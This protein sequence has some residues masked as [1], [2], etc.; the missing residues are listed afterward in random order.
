MFSL[1]PFV[2]LFTFLSL[3]LFSLGQDRYKIKTGDPNGI[4]KWYMGRQIA[5]VM[6]HYG[7][8][9]LE[10]EEREME[11]NTSLLLKNLSVK[12]GMLIADIGAGSGYHSALLSKMV[13]TGKVFAVDVEPEM[14]AYLNER[15][16]QEKLAR[17]VP[18][19]STEQKVSLPDNTVDMMLLVDVYHE[20]SY[21]YEMALSMRAALKSGGKLVLVEFR[22]EDKSVPIKTIHKM[23]EAQAIKE[24]KAAG[25][26]FDKNIDNLPWQHCMVFIKQ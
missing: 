9:W 24:F 3:S 17:I 13:G 12:P 5:Q 26:T 22:S 21:P 6:S 16:K 7:I 8:D 11:E 2:L 20:F 4:N 23:S 19:L 10:R 14:I 18:V 15:I 25:F 1:K